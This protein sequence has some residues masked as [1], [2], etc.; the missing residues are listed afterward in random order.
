[1][2]ASENDVW[3]LPPSPL[4]PNLFVFQPGRVERQRRVQRGGHIRLA[5]RGVTPFHLPWAERIKQIPTPGAIRLL[6]PPSI[7]NGAFTIETLWYQDMSLTEWIEKIDAAKKD[8]SENPIAARFRPANYI[9]TIENLF[10]NNQRKR[11]L[12]R[13]TLQRWTQRVWLKRT[14]CNVDMIDMTE[15]PEKDAIFLTDTK[16]HQI[17]RFHKNDVFTNLLTNLGMAD[18]MLPSPRY[19]TNPW[20]N[21]KLT[22]AQTMTIC[23][24]LVR[25]YAARGLCPPVIFAAFWA[26][27]FSLRRFQDQNSALLSQQAI[28]SFF[29]DLHEHNMSTVLDTITN[30]L[31]AA[32]VDFSMTGFSRWLRQTPQTPIHREWLQMAR[33]Y[34]LYINLHIQVRAR[35]Y[36]EDYIH[37]DVRAL[38]D[39]TMIPDATSARMR[40]LRSAAGLSEAILP[41]QPPMYSLLGLSALLR[42]PPVLIDVSGGAMTNA[43]A[44]QLIQNALFRM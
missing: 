15:I 34:T 42:P 16:H 13:M 19:P 22:M 27:R 8:I 5:S 7:A 10:Y 23:Q 11:W 31:Y 4:T 17:Y 41:A 24:Q 2:D 18:E 25:D 6:S 29:K 43:M 3:T 44:L 20:T 36:T 39:R 30:L 26:S 35:W 9:E 12:A 28:R 33:D 37:A 21:T 38:Y 32:N 1:M 40:L 14:Q